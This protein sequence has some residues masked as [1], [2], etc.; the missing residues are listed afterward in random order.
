[1]KVDLAGGVKYLEL[2]DT[3]QVP[4]TLHAPYAAGILT[5]LNFGMNT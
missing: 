5:F 4:V 3:Q 2:D 1:M